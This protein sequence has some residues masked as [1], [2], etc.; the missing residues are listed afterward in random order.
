MNA[1]RTLRRSGFS[2]IELLVVLAL[3]SI[4]MAFTF[5]QF[6][7]M[8]ARIKI[9]G[10]ARETV[11]LMR[12]ARIEAVRRSC[13]GV[14]MIDPALKQVVAFADLDSDGIFDATDVLVGRLDLPT[15]LSFKDE[16]GDTG[17]DSVDGLDNPD[18]ADKQVM[19]KNDGSVLSIGAIRLADHR[20]NLLEVNVDPQATGRVQIRKYNGTEWLAKGEGAREWT[21]Q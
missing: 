9:E 10:A 16:D 12:A 14:V 1:R 19:Y 11:T 6:L 17:L 3:F 15:Q 13:Y 7:G 2:L 4:I 21:F 20:G 5:P 18:L 8:L